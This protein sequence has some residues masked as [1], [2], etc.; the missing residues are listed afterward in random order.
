[1]ALILVIYFFT[2]REFFYL[3]VFSDQICNFFSARNFL[4]FIVFSNEICNFFSARDFFYFIVFCDEICNLFTARDFLYFISDESCILFNGRD[5]LYFIVFSDDICN[6]FI[7]RT[8]LYVNAFSDG[9][10]VF[11]AARNLFYFIFESWVFITAWDLFCFIFESWIFIAAWDLF[12]IITERCVFIA[13]LDLFYFIDEGCV[14]IV[15]WDLVYVIV[16]RD[17]SFVFRFLSFLNSSWWALFFVLFFQFF[18]ILLRHFFQSLIILVGCDQI[19]NCFTQEAFGEYVEKFIQPF[20]NFSFDCGV[21]NF[22][23][24]RIVIV[25]YFNGKIWQLEFLHVV[26]W[27]E[28][29][30]ILGHYGIFRGRKS[31]LR[32]ILLILRSGI[33]V[34]GFRIGLC[35]DITMIFLLKLLQ[36][37]SCFFMLDAILKAILLNLSVF[38]KFFAWITVCSANGLFSK[39]IIRD[40]FLAFCAH[41][42]FFCELIML[43]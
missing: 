43:T 35:T 39:L 24:L 1:M 31:E 8:L 13:T 17:G 2:A 12:N 33:I 4:Y 10:Y 5:F 11:I 3:I 27:G 6:F 28:R 18:F 20:V 37:I 41:V 25:L 21:S 34:R 16:F 38:G 9:S 30:L 22:S 42:R 19:W 15:V 36:V 14:F 26:A 7:D 40:F 32:F 23:G 29:C